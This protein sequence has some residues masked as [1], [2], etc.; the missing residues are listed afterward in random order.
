MNGNTAGNPTGKRR[1][2]CLLNLAAFSAPSDL[3]AI[4]DGRRCPRPPRVLHVIPTVWYEGA[5]GHLYIDDI[6]RAREPQQRSA[7][8]PAELCAWRQRVYLART[9]RGAQETDGAHGLCHWP[10]ATS[11]GRLRAELPQEADG[12]NNRMDYMYTLDDLTCVLLTSIASTPASVCVALNALAG[13]VEY[14]NSRSV[15]GV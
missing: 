15:G 13:K 7:C 9:D 14:A 2:S 4:N 12:R 6:T 8:L 10:K 5:K 1:A 3:I 11:M